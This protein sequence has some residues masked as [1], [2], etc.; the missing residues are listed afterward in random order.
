MMTRLYL[1]E[2]L[3]LRAHV[4]R[5]IVIRVQATITIIEALRRPKGTVE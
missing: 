5:V 1:R 3:L 2:Q 4:T